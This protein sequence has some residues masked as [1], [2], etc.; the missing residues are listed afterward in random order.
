MTAPRFET[1]SALPRAGGAPLALWLGYWRFWQRYHRYTVEGLEHLDG[2]PA[3]I[4][5]YHGR[6]LAYDMC[7]L[8]V[9]LYD[10]LGYL[11]HGFV[12]RGTKTLGVLRWFTDGL[13]FVTED[14]ETLAAALG[15]G[16]HLVTT[17]GGG[18]EGC[19]DFRH[20]YEVSWGERTGYL[21]LAL[22]YGLPIVPVA[23][24]GADDTFIGL[25]DVEAAGRLLGVP[26]RWAWAL[27]TG[28]GPLGLYPFSPPFP[29]RLRQVVGAPID[30]V[31][32][33]APSLDDQ[34]GL[35]R[36]HRRVTAAV[37]ALLDR[38]RRRPAV[39]ST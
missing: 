39:R 9:A 27:W 5:G 14:G 1:G 16:E 36:L 32:E 11:P 29:V 10:R 21:R 23:A 24:D 31:S 13:G 33:G 38:V 15:R 28:I 2:G 7:M 19:R 34:E 20:R 8:T 30:L 4:V 35:L 25:V 17:P 3:L 18:A 12:H 37:Q 22:K 26:R 6:P